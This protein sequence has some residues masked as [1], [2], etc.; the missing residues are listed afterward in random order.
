MANYL[1]YLRI[2][3]R[4]F[5]RLITANTTSSITFGALPP[6]IEAKA[7]SRYVIKTRDLFLALGEISRLFPMAKADLF[8]TA[9]A[10]AEDDWFAAPI[11]PTNSPSYLRIYVCT[12]ADGIL[13]VAR[14]ISG[15]TITENLNGGSDLSADASYMFTVPWRTGDEINLRYSVPVTVLRCTIDEIGG[16][17]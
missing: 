10:L 9:I 4:D 8:N 6:G 3:D 5:V 16:A 12:D 17:E 7:G 14:T 11:T 2:G 1:V 13:R 15:V